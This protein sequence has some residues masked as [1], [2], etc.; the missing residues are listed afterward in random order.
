MNG[1]SKGN[2]GVVVVGGVIRDNIGSWIVRFV[3][4]NDICSLFRFELWV[5]SV[6]LQLTWVKGFQNVILESDSC[7][8]IGLINDDRVGMDKNYNLTMQIKDMLGRDWEVKTLYF[9]R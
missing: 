7:V 1:C 2:S 6:S 3:R 8:V 5:V 9:Y 4:N